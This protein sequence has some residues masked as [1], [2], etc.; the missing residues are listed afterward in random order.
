MVRVETENALKL[1]A[2][3]DQQPVEAFAA[4]VANPAFDVRV[5]VRCPDG[6]PDRPDPRGTEDCVEGSNF[7]S[8]SWI[9]KC[10]G[11]PRS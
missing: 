1:A 8:R 11:S 9:R 7:A 3:E 4:K 6:R 2:I 5:G 10:G